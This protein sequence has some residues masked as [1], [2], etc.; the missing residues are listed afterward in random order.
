MFIVPI[1]CV[2]RLWNACINV[3]PLSNSHVLWLLIIVY[4]WHIAVYPL[5]RSFRLSIYGPLD[6]NM[7]Y[8]LDLYSNLKFDWKSSILATCTFC[9]VN[10]P[11]NCIMTFTAVRASVI[12]AIWPRATPRP[13]WTH[14]CRSS[15]TTRRNVGEQ[16]YGRCW[17]K[18]RPTRCT[19]FTYCTEWSRWVDPPRDSEW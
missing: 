2:N 1:V 10:L 12:S 7:V 13:T 6:L 16:P 8:T 18:R 4:I 3:Y 19:C 5:R 15:G 17:T 14:S 9:V 11:L